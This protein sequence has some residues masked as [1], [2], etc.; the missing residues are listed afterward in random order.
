MN[1]LNPYQTILM[2]ATITVLSTGCEIRE[3]LEATVVPLGVDPDK[4]KTGIFDA[5]ILVDTI[6]DGSGTT[7]GLNVLY[8]NGGRVLPEGWDR[9][10]FGTTTEETDTFSLA[11]IAEA[12]DQ[13]GSLTFD[14]VNSNISRDTQLVLASWYD[15]NDNG[16]LDLSMTG[17]SEMVRSPYFYDEDEKTKVYLWAVNYKS[18]GTDPY[19]FATALGAANGTNYILDDNGVQDNAWM[20][21]I[22]RPMDAPLNTNLEDQIED[23]TLSDEDNG[24]EDSSTDE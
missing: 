1:I 14:V 13:T 2:I 20:I 3:P 11:P 8:E 5:N 24:T 4:V 23:D 9:T 18:N 6:E 15:A 7:V 21:L 16:N 22:D 12:S 10:S 19:Y 17:E